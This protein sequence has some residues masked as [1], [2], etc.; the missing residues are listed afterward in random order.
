MS[1]LF[2]RQSQVDTGTQQ[3]RSLLTLFFSAFLLSPFDAATPSAGSESLAL[4]DSKAFSLMSA[5]PGAANDKDEE[6][7]LS[8]GLDGVTKEG[9]LGAASG[10]PEDTAVWPF[11][12]ACSRTKV[13]IT[14]RLN[15]DSGVDTR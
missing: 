2:G 15:C 9:C 6:G 4:P 3:S 5:S 10:L 1:S 13:E 14:S 11:A 12:P 7:E 8:A